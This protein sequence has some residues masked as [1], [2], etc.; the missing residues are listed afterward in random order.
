M[1]E[2]MN[3]NEVN[4]NGLF[5]ETLQELETQLKTDFKLMSG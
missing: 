4:M 2:L 5:D 3:F 1:K